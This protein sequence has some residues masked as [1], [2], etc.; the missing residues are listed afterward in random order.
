MKSGTGCEHIIDQ[1]DALVFDARGIVYGEGSSKICESFFFQE[2]CLRYRRPNPEKTGHEQRDLK[3][4]EE[5]GE[6]LGDDF[7]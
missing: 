6:D 5:M 2:G 1:E 4:G 7:A 3:M